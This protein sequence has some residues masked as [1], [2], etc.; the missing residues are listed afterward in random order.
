MLRSRRKFFQPSEERSIVTFQNG[1]LPQSAT[2]SEVPESP[3]ALPALRVRNLSF[4]YHKT[5]VLDDVSMDVP[6]RATTAIIGPSGCGKSTFLKALNRIGELESNVRVQGT[7]E[8]F[9]QDIYSRRVN[10]N[11]LRRR[12][13]MVFQKPNPF[14]T[15]VYNNAAYGIAIAERKPRKELDEIVEKA[16]RNA[17]LWDEVKDKLN[18]S[19]LGLSGGQQQRLCIARALAV[20]PDVLL[21]DEPCSALDPVSTAKIEELI[22]VLSE[23]LTIAIVTHNMQQ[24]HR[25]SK[26]TAFFNTDESRI[27]RLVEFGETEIV[28]TQ[29]SQPST[30]DYV[31]GRFG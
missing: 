4:F 9:G 27:G 11:R 20:E 25:V 18:R 22:R 19:A 5:Q 14:P 2:N 12:I 16:L 13:G 17:A 30:R 29:A 8:F 31:R 6:A 1:F 28:F 10:L 7:V 24:A 3:A 15:T 21:M 23:R 26:Y